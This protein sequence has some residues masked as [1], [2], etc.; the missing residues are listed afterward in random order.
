MA[1]EGLGGWFRLERCCD[2]FAISVCQQ[3]REAKKERRERSLVMI[4]AFD[5]NTGKPVLKYFN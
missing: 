5:E 3:R 4:G 1:C 2:I